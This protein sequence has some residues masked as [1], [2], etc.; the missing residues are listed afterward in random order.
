M[1]NRFMNVCL[2]ICAI[3]LMRIMNHTKL[4]YFFI[5][6]LAVNIVDCI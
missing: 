2:L 3:A 6:N 1:D 5:S 4:V